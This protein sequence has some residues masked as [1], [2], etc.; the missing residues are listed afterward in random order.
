M[1]I[2][3]S[4]FHYLCIRIVQSCFWYKHLPCFLNS[5]PSVL[6]TEAFPL[7]NEAYRGFGTVFANFSTLAFLVFACSTASIWSVGYNAMAA[8]SLCW[9]GGEGWL[10]DG[11]LNFQSW[12]LGRVGCAR[13][14]KHYPILTRTYSTLCYLVVVV[15]YKRRDA[16]SSATTSLLN[17]SLCAAIRLQLHESGFFWFM[18][19]IVCSTVG[20]W[21]MNTCVF[22]ASY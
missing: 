11:L 9:W 16:M 19:L 10:P 7:G 13:T 20:L 18:T 2:Y 6:K 8:T 4:I 1:N 14:Q 5:L 12:A 17:L 15:T 22:I 3:N 21:T